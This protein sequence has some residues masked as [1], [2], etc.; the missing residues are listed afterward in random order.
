MVRGQ[1]ADE[2][3]ELK[4]L[5]KIGIFDNSVTPPVVFEAEHEFDEGQIDSISSANVVVASHRVAESISS[6]IT[7][8]SRIILIRLF[9]SITE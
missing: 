8:K 2:Y 4:T 1:I 9:L 7:Q 6:S 3:K 5:K